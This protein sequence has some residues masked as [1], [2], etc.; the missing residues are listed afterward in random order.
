AL[1][2][3]FVVAAVAIGLRERGLLGMLRRQ[4]LL[5]G[6]GALGAIAGGGVVAVRGLGYYAGARHLHFAPAA[7]GRNATVLLYAGGWAIMPGALIGV[8]CAGARPP[9]RAERAFAWP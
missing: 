3:C 6:A 2:L 9:T 4:R 1:F 7:F 5:L 8:W